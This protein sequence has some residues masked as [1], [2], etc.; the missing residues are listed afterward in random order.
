MSTAKKISIIIPTYNS[1]KTL[2]KC[3]SSFLD[4]TYPPHE[5]ITVDGGSTDST[6][7]IIKSFHNVKW[8]INKKRLQGP[9]R[10]RG[11]ETAT[12]DILFF[13]DHDCIADKKVL[14][15]HIKVYNNRSDISGIMG[16]IGN[17]SP[18]NDISNFVQKEFISSQWLRSLNS[19]GTVKYFQTGT[20]N[21]SMYR[22]EFLK[23]K[24]PEDPTV[25]EDTELSMRMDGKVKILFEPRAIVYHHHPS[26]VEELFKQRKYYGERFFGLFRYKKGNLVFQPDSFFYSAMRF[27]NF[28]EDWLSKA[29]T[30][31]N[32]LLCE[33]CK[34]QRC[35]IDVPKNHISGTSDEDLSKLV[36]LAFSSGILKQRTG[37]DISWP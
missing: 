21:F 29:V 17:A 28:S 13:C 24:F 12:G 32:R 35:K 2:Q 7:K 20:Y 18:R 22:S 34:I 25:S 6:E 8:L 36:C 33:G 10:N 14:E 27:I 23:W 31:D 4:Q 1:E 16:A 5:I 11:A 37:K 30:K 9:G 3:L 26:T 15:Y 19:D